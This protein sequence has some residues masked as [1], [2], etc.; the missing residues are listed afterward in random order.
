MRL[1][2]HWVGAT[3]RGEPQGV[4]NLSVLFTSSPT[5]SS[6]PLCHASI[7]FLSRPNALHR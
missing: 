2:I 4:M 3:N 5:V 6:Q 1:D 7:L